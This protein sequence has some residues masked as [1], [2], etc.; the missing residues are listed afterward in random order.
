M[1]NHQ[2]YTLGGVLLATT[3]LTAAAEA[4][5]VGV[6]VGGGFTDISSTARRLSTSVF[7]TTNANTVSIGGVASNEF[8][9]VFANSFGYATTFDTTIT[10]SGAQFTVGSTVSADLLLRGASGTGTFA[11][12]ASGATA[13]C[14]V[15]KL[16]NQ[17]FVENCKLTLSQTLGAA[18]AN[19]GG[20]L[21]KGVAFDTASG[22]A[23]AGASISLAGQ[24]VLDGTTT[25]LETITSGN[26]VTSAAPLTATVQGGSVTANAT[27]TPTPYVN[28]VAST[29]GGGT[30]LTLA[31]IS[32][33]ATGALATDL[34]L[35]VI[36]D[37]NGAAQSTVGTTALDI[38]LTS[39]I[40]SDAA[41]T[42]VVLSD[43]DSVLSTK[44][45][46]AFSGTTVTFNVLAA[47]AGVTYASSATVTVNF[48]GTAAIASAAA[49]TISATLTAGGSSQ[50]NPAAASGT[51]TSIT[52]G[53]LSAEINTAQN[54]FGDGS[55]KYQS[56][57]RI[58][59]NGAVA[60]AASIQVYND[61]TGALIGTYTSGSILPNATVQLS[62]KD[63]ETQ[64]GVTPTGFGQY[65]LKVSGPFVGYAQ[66]VMLNSINGAF[67]DLSSYRNNDQAA[68]AP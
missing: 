39:P 27:A 67:S 48:N 40:L 53:G 24:V 28:L 58:H 46:A 65:T 60:G 59:N 57:V 14:S 37:D 55:S 68:G 18:S 22:L 47:T 41:L 8:A 9:I 17:I 10:I 49:G 64:L 56:F 7:P 33:T 34:S 61:S 3:S 16:V 31:S 62:M 66:H 12:T 23:T 43:N 19:I 1:K 44:T 4:A 63:I 11:A 5:T 32:I 21:L 6:K 50:V 38:T 36:A 45:A 13:A 52:R 2:L 29:V 15:T 20:L 54:S 30:S 42:S 35:L 51:T 25:V 26:V